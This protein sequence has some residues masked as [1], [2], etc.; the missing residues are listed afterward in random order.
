MQELE[1]TKSSLQEE[2]NT[3]SHENQ[4]IINQN[5][6]LNDKLQSYE[7][8]MLKNQIRPEQLS[9]QDS[10]TIKSQE[11]LDHSSNANTLSYLA[12][13]CQTIQNHNAREACPDRFK[14]DNQ[15]TIDR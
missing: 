1:L 2:V 14:S 7:T 15:S 9:Q 8:Q 3:L 5:K 12:S 10:T 13:N 6:A 4:L 11:N